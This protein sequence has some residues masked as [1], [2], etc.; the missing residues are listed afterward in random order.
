MRWINRLSSKVRVATAK[1]QLR[2]IDH[3]VT[4]RILDFT[5]KRITGPMAH[6]ERVRLSL[7]RWVSWTLLSRGLSRDLRHPNGALRTSVT[8]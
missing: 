3:Q 8:G 1:I 7:A 4:E 2:I 6:A 5:A